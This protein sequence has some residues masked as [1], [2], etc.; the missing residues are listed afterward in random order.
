[1]RASLTWLQHEREAKAREGGTFA[2][3]ER[4]VEASDPIILHC[5]QIIGRPNRC[6]TAPIYSSANW[7][8]L[9]MTDTGVTCVVIGV[10][11]GA[12]HLRF[13]V[14]VLHLGMS[15]GEGDP[16]LGVAA[17]AS[18]CGVSARRSRVAERALGFHAR[19]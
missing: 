11:L 10:A 7:G 5:V 6:L 12:G 9:L 13:P 8:A 16:D 3:L 19:V 18:S 15:E 2:Q 17:G 1:M 14:A 4:W